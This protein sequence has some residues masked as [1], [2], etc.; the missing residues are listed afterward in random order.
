MPLDVNI[1]DTNTTLITYQGGWELLVGSTRQWNGT[2]HSTLQPGASATF[3]FRGYQVWVWGTIPA[4]VGSNLVDFSID[5][6][7]P[8]VTSR[9]SNGSAVYNEPYYASPTLR[10]TYHTIVVTNRGS[11]ANGNTEFLLDRFEFTS[12]DDVP[13]FSPSGTS[14]IPAATAPATSSGASGSASTPTGGSKTPIGAIV[15]PVIGV[16]AAAVVILAYLLWRRRRTG[17]SND[18]DDE[19]KASTRR[20]FSS[21]RPQLA[22]TPFQIDET[23]A[24][25]SQGPTDLSSSLSDNATSNA[26]TREPPSEKSGYRNLNLEGFRSPSTDSAHPTSAIG[27]S[28]RPMASSTT[29]V[30]TSSNPPSHT[31]GPFSPL[32]PNNDTASSMYT[33]HT[34]SQRL[35]AFSTLQPMSEVPSSTEEDFDHPPPSYWND[36]QEATGAEQRPNLSN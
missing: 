19:K 34:T 31:T 16:L 11:N 36:A 1:D 17:A 10:D 3:Q 12:S 15:G 9:A 23:P 26:G 8:N 28:P 30:T 20:F 5:G 6:S 25:A 4:G 22:L 18:T 13:L 2:V 32:S 14:S 24:T 29:L 33:P 27:A 21:R 35:E 7:T